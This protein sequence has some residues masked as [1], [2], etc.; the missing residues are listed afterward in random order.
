MHTF[1]F[2]FLDG[3]VEQGKGTSVSDAFTKLGYGAGAIASL[4]YYEQLN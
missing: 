3:S 4:D 2:Y 1:K